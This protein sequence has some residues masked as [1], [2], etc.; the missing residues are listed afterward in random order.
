MKF[1]LL[2]ILLSCL[3]CLMVNNCCVSSG[4]DNVPNELKS[5]EKGIPLP[6]HEDL[7]EM[8]KSR[9][10]K[11]VSSVFL[12][13]EPFLDSALTERKMPL[14]LKYL[15]LSLSGMRENYRQGDRCGYW[16]MP[17]LVGM[18]YGLSVDEENDER[19]DMR[20]ATVAALDYISDLYKNYQDWWYAILAYT[21]S[22]NTLNQALVHT[23]TKP[24]PWDFYEQKLM[25]DSQVIADFISYVYLANEDS[26]MFA[27]IIEPEEPVVSSDE[28][29]ETMRTTTDAN[30]S[31]V[32]K[33]RIKKGDTLT[34]I[35]AM[36]QVKI[37][38]LME[39][40]NLSD[41]KILEGQILIIKK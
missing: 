10:S 1:R 17:T 30:E 18:R 23:G 31:S 36:Y 14:E 8:L 6:Y 21:N 9:A 2:F 33:H 22:P 40:N 32:I 28:P 7:A 12:Q 35:A 20:S 39:W 38:E 26:L 13:Y 16:A 27:E 41:D 29:E 24:S 37:S 19:L 4:M 11:P 34:K 3:V 5:T 15:P 25:P